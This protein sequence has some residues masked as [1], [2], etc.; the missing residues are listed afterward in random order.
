MEKLILSCGRFS[1]SAGEGI[2]GRVRALE[3]YLARLSEEL[4]FLLPLL[5][6][7]QGSAADVT[8]EV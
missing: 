5:E 2:E 3:A 8:E 6:G 1:P 4:E 7:A